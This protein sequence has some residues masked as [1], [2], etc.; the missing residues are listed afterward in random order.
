MKVQS[1]EKG[2]WL[3][4]KIKSERKKVMYNSQGENGT[5]SVVDLHEKKKIVHDISEKKK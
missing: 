1:E 5:G 3:V 2:K 4:L